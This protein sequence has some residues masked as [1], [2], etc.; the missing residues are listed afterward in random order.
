MPLTRTV[1]L[2]PADSPNRLK[3]EHGYPR[4]DIYE[5]ADRS[6]GRRP[7]IVI[8][9]GG[10]YGHVSD[11]HEGRNFD[12]RHPYPYIELQVRHDRETGKPVSY[13]WNGAHKTIHR[14]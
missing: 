14:Y 11:P 6:A 9:P 3:S 8:L 10:G 2:W 13:S 5:P 12:N 4:I 7:A 1:E